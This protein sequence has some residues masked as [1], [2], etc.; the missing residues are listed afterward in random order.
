MSKQDK[1]P[2]KEYSEKKTINKAFNRGIA[3][4]LE[5]KNRF[6]ITENEHIKAL[7]KCQMEALLKH[8]QTVFKNKKDL[9]TAGNISLM[10]LVISGQK[11]E[12]SNN[13]KVKVRAFVKD[14]LIAVLDFLQQQK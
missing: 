2:K 9:I 11:F 1:K 7:Y 14:Q 6:E 10:E 8:L 3:L 5:F 12:L 4:Y 13:L